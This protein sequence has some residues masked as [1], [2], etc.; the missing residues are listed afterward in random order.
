MKYELLARIEKELGLVAAHRGG[1][2][3]STLLSDIRASLVKPDHLSPWHPMTDPV[4]LKHM[5]KFLEEL[6]ECSAAAARCVVD[7]VCGK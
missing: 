5:G 3:D 1:I 7:Q 4:D 2:S 6:G